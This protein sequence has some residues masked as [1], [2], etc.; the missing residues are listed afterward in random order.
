MIDI[1]ENLIEYRFLKKYI[2][3]Q[4]A[5]GKYL[6]PHR[7]LK[8]QNDENKGFLFYCRRCNVYFLIMIENIEKKW[9]LRW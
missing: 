4:C 3:Y 7:I 8:S 6:K 9:L 1:R 5:C 2:H